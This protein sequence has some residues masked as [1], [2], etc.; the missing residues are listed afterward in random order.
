MKT[1]KLKERYIER[2]NTHLWIFSNEIAKHDFTAENGEI[3]RI[4]YSDDTQCGIGFYN[5]HSLISVR[6][7]LKGKE[8]MDEHFF[9]NCLNKAFDYRKSI[10]IVNGR[11]FFGESD[12][13]G[14]LV[15]D[16]YNSV[17]TVQI[18]SAGVEKSTLPLIK[19][20]STSE[21]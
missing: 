14:G 4:V 3:C 15:I 10:G 6:L 12:G 7:L 9:L 1:I 20:V 2:L 13:I 18:L 11:F 5:P 16:K 19:R 21:F 8:D 17:I